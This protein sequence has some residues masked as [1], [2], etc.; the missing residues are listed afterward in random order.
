MSFFIVLIGL[1]VVSLIMLISV[2]II[3]SFLLRRD[4]AKPPKSRYDARGFDH[5]HLHRNGTKFDDY[6]YDYLGYNKDGYNAQGYNAY[7][8]NIKGKYNR[9]YDTKS[10]VEEGFLSPYVRPVALSDH[11]RQ[12][13]AERLGIT[14][15]QKMQTQAVEAYKYGKSKRQIKKTS[16]YLI[17]EI[18]NRYNSIVL[19]YRNYIYVFSCDNV[20]ITVYKNDKIV[21]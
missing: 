4:N 7:G 1:A 21:L 11:A 18:E 9:F 6:G 13:M 3:L 10:S 17:E 15:P 20:L 12:R 16:A 8:K 5:N 14:E 19:V 2:I